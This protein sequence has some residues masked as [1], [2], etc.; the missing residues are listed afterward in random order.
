MKI[1]Y[2]TDYSLRVL[3]YLST[4]ND[5]A[6]IAEIAESFKVSKNHLV[7]VVHN[8]SKLNLIETNKGKNGGI[9]LS[10]QA[11]KFRLG[12]L[13]ELLEPLS[14]VE[15]FDKDTN[16][17]PIV[18]VCELE[19]LLYR[20]RAAFLDQLN[21]ATLGSLAESKHQSEKKKRLG[22]T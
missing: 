6:T 16:L 22:L 8:L 21:L 1:S 2:F 3:L 17:C 9:K 20:G 15:C 14:L 18:G 13:V 19:K 12:K 10:R 7:K 4:K 11:E 5:Q